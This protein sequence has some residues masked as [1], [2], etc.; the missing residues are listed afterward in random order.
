M[1]NG[2]FP[3]LP[4]RE[5]LPDEFQGGIGVWGAAQ[6]AVRKAVFSPFDPNGGTH[7]FLGEKV[8]LHDT[9]GRVDGHYELRRLDDNPDSDDISL[10][11]LD[12]N[13]E[14]IDVVDARISDDGTV[15]YDP[16]GEEKIARFLELVRNIG[17]GAIA[18]VHTR[19]TIKAIDHTVI[20]DDPAMVV[21][22][23]IALH[24]AV[25]TASEG[26]GIP[27][28]VSAEARFVRVFFEPADPTVD[29]NDYETTEGLAA[30][31]G[32]VTQRRVLTYDNRTISLRGGRATQVD[33]WL[34]E[35]ELVDG[36]EAFSRQSNPNVKEITE[37]LD[38]EF[39]PPVVL[40]RGPSDEQWLH[41]IQNPLNP[42]NQLQDPAL[43]A[44]FE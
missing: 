23:P 10:T 11:R 2:A 22:A 37:R 6:V 16:E 8:E 42:D 35:D 41:L 20:A 18:G 43:R 38:R 7:L 5:V 9:A 28:V 40:A 30:I 32:L 31:E 14:G 15:I 1:A 34:P 33:Y 17:S 24:L 29:P 25:T 4:L 3:E 12:P 26:H 44:Q 36:R 19:E 13:S 21:E 27:P 39:H